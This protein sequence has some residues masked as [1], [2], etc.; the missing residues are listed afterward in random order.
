MINIMATILI[1]DDDTQSRI[2]LRM[3]LERAGYKV[4]E[5]ENGRAGMKRQREC[6]ADLIITD[7]I[8]PEKEGIETIIAFRIEFPDT[9]IIAI[10][11]GGKMRSEKYLRMDAT[12]GAHRVLF[13]PFAKNEILEAIQGLLNS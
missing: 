5:A 3:S 1:I 6:Q 10:S 7:I 4:V 9:K 11:G 2:F 8:M 13:R 12:I